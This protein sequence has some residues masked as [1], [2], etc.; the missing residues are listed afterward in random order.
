MSDKLTREELLAAL[1]GCADH[2]DAEGNHLDTEEAHLYADRALLDHI[3]DPE[4]TAAF[5]ESFKW[6]A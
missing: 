3:D 6:Y 4:V 5:D 2:R 1:R